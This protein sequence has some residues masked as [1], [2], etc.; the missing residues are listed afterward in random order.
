MHMVA[1]MMANATRY[2]I[3]K[4]IP[5]E[6]GVGCEEELC[7]GTSCSPHCAYKQALLQCR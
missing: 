5:V 7:Q 3:L 2:A 1:T 4:Y 6:A